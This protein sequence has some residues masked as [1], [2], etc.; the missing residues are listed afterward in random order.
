MQK[1]N[2]EKEAE[3]RKAREEEDRIAAEEEEA[4]NSGR[5]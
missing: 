3:S 2:V 4:R 1:S 5:P